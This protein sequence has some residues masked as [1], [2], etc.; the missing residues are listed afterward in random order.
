ML[1][2]FLSTGCYED[3]PMPVKTP[4][5]RSDRPSSTVKTTMQVD[6][7]IA[8]LIRRLS[9]FEGRR[10]SETLERMFE[11]YMRSEHPG[12]ELVYKSG[13]TNGEGR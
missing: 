2:A 3:H 9:G 12:L 8:S 6:E 10:L 11:C 13:E 1:L 5:T 7:R 4:E